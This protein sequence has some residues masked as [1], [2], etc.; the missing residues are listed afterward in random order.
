MNRRQLLR[1]VA[2]SAVLAA[3]DACSSASHGSSAA[4][5]ATT[6]PASAA[7]AVTGAGVAPAPAASGSAVADATTTAVAATSPPIP[8]TT[9]APATSAP[10]PVWTPGS[11]A[12]YVDQG[13]S[14]TALVALTFH[15]AGAP[16]LALQLLDLLKANSVSSTLF[17]IG[18]WLT[19]HPALGHRALADGHELGNHTKSHQSMLQL[20]RAQVHAEIAGGGAALVPFIGSIGRWFRPSGTDVPTSL[21][22]EE[23]GKVGYPVS[24]GYDIDSLDYTEP[25]AAAVVAAVNPALR[26]GS[27]VSLHFGHA[28]TL[29]ALPQILDRIG[30]LRLRTATVSQLLTPTAPA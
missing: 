18:D 23:A 21:I 19:A 9:A 16:A 8:P 11:A 2:G 1:G 3:L 30:A 7:P 14:D 29:A 4:P 25:G 5:T 27:I 26:A 6:G 13:P 10:A 15:F 24:V 12:T 22:L 28:D 17:A 20:G